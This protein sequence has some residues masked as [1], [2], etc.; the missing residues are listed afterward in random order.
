MI[1]ALGQ[2]EPQTEDHECSY[3]D[4]N[5]GDG[6]HQGPGGPLHRTHASLTRV[7]GY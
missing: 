6:Q 3:S 4:G 5:P 7:R 2:S 1:S